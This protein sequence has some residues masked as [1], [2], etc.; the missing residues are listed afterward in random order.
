MRLTLTKKELKALQELS[1]Q[2]ASAKKV[3]NL[4]VGVEKDPRISQSKTADGRFFNIDVSEELATEFILMLK[5]YTAEALSLT[6]AQ[7]ITRGKG[8]LKRVKAD[9]NSLLSRYK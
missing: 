4:L 7:L 8:L 1:Q 2:H 6:T 5:R 9:A 3:F